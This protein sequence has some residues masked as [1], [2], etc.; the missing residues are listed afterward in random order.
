MDLSRLP[1]ISRL[2]QA[3]AAGLSG[4]R[5]T[6]LDLGENYDLCDAGGVA[7]LSSVKGHPTLTKLNLNSTSL[8]A[9]SA[10][11]IQA[12]LPTQA[13]AAA[14]VGGGGSKSGAGG[15]AKPS[16]GKAPKQQAGSK[17]PGVLSDLSVTGNDD[18]PEAV[19]QMVADWKTRQW[20]SV[21]G[22]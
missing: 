5:L 2:T 3:L 11:A 20:A 4:S 8:T 13:P 10:P 19:V 22:L 1:L 15:S 14:A 21:H 12:L 9:K 6:E 17:S 7:I 16:I 18:L